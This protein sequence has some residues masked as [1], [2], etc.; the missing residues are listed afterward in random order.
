M[1]NKSVNLLITLIAQFKRLNLFGRIKCFSGGQ[2]VI[3]ELTYCFLIN[4][5]VKDICPFRKAQITVSDL[6]KSKIQVE[7]KIWLSV[8]QKKIEDRLKYSRLSQACK[9]NKRLRQSE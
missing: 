8:S 2:D 1:K 7:I 6:S 3:Y 4:N 5:K 9:V